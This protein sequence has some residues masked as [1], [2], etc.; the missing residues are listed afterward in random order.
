[1]EQFEIQTETQEPHL[2]AY[3]PEVKNN[4]DFTECVL[5]HVSAAIIT[6]DLNYII[7]GWNKAA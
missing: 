2:H 4:T 3:V 1:M 5:A 7:T 6:T